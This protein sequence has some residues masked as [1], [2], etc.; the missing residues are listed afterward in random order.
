[1]T[2]SGDSEEV[3]Y[4]RNVTPDFWRPNFTTQKFATRILDW[5]EEKCGM[6]KKTAESIFKEIGYS[7]EFSIALKTHD[8][9]EVLQLFDEENWQRHLEG[10]RQG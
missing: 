2:E 7:R 10:Y 1:M 4:P 5:V 3:L 6:S 8:Q 9:Q